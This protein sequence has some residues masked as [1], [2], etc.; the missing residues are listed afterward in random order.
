[1]VAFLAHEWP[2]IMGGRPPTFSYKRPACYRAKKKEDFFLICHSVEENSTKATKSESSES[3]L[4]LRRGR[5][6]DPDVKSLVIENKG[7]NHRKKVKLKD[8]L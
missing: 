3:R 8:W 4:C 6:M 5:F 2:S 7:V 1:M